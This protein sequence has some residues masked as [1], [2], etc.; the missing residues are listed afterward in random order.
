MKNLFLIGFIALVSVC[1]SMALGETI[2]SN[3]SQKELSENPRAD[4]GALGYGEAGVFGR[5]FGIDRY[6]VQGEN[7]CEGGD[8][9]AIRGDSYS[10]DG[11]GVLGHGY[12]SGVMGMG[13]KL[14]V[15]GESRSPKGIGV[16]G[17]T[18]TR[19]GISYGVIGEVMSPKGIGV[20]GKNN[21]SA[22][23]TIGV[24]GTTISSH[25]IGVRGINLKT[26]GFGW[27]VVGESFGY[28]P[29]MLGINYSNSG[30]TTGVEGAIK[31]ETGVAVNGVSHANK[32]KSIGVR[33]Y[34]KSVE[35]YPGWFEGGQG[36]KIPVLDA[37]PKSPAEGTIWINR[38]EAALKMRVN[39]I[40]VALKGST[41]ASGEVPGGKIWLEE[42]IGA[43]LYKTGGEVRHLRGNKM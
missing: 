3:L 25:G 14:G 39:G 34:T 24:L 4:Y 40:T 17:I 36:I 28:G 43:L 11:I 32:G 22:G 2:V 30:Y 10:P 15:V 21:A 38:K 35:G 12:G 33:G 23:D 6:G 41:T 18:T 16:K 8:A 31:S 27:G 42:D 13:N 29:A 9:V 1:E 19:L 26:G 7:R 37:D 5:T 20:L